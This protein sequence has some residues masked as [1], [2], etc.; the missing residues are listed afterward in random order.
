MRA[1]LR[2]RFTELESGS[3]PDRST[4]A[5]AAESSAWRPAPILQELKELQAREKQS[6]R[7]LAPD[8]HADAL[9]RREK[10][11]RRRKLKWIRRD[12]KPRVDLEDKAAVNAILNADVIRKLR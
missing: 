11:A 1:G 10:P 9:A 8:L 12:R 4:S 6:L 3:A 7:Q 2:C 5:I